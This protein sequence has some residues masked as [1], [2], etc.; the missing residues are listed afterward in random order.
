[1]INLN[2]KD[3][4]ILMVTPNMLNE[5]RGYR[6]FSIIRTES[7]SNYN[8]NESLKIKIEYMSKYSITIKEFYYGEKILFTGYDLISLDNYNYIFRGNTL[9]METE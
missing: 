5:L 7:F 4:K 2:L 8:N 6:D 9:I 1:M 3:G